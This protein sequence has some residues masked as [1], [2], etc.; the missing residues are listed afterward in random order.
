MSL[1]YS[2]PHSS[3][4]AHSLAAVCITPNSNPTPSCIGFS[5]Y[6]I[7]VAMYPLATYSF[8]TTLLL[9]V[10]CCIIPLFCFF[11]AFSPH[12]SFPFFC[13]PPSLLPLTHP[14]FPSFLP[15]KYTL[16]FPFHPLS[17]PLLS[18]SLS[19]SLFSFN[20]SPFTITHFLHHSFICHLD[21][22]VTS[23]ILQPSG[24]K[25]KLLLNITSLHLSCSK[26]WF[27]SCD[28]LM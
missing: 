2:C 15:F 18:V 20:F 19:V 26:M 21:S 10:L 3:P 23:S 8:V 5:L 1:A 12:S 14:P 11:F 28:S 13:F 24:L 16:P 22:T 17:F 27:V 6:T 7:P 9:L 25:L 4:H